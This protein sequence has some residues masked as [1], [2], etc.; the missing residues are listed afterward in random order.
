MA[1]KLL[2]SWFS[3]FA[4]RVQIAL[5]IKGLEYDN[6]EETWHPKSELLLH[7]NPVYKKIPVF[8]HGDKIICESAIIVEYIDEVWKDNGTPS[9][10]PSNAF[11]SAIARFWV[12][13]I[14][15]KFFNS[16]RNGLIAQDEESKKKHFELVEEVFMRLE[17]VIN[18]CNN[19][20]MEFFGGDKIGYIDIGF[21]CYMSWVRATEKIEGIKLLDGAKTPALVK[22]AEAFADHPA[23]KGVL[24][25]TDKL[26]EFA[27]GYVKILVD[28]ASK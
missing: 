14:D 6:I 20:G 2:G 10:F 13:Y 21:G 7:S 16:V 4:C 5:N 8:S 15:D 24:P 23:V 12:A 27:K 11:D 25:E 26:V 22:W 9:I 17:E 1:L 19:E 18:K 28:K 3:P